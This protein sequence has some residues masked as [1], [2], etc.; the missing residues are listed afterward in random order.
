M[1]W[2]SSSASGGTL[3]SHVFVWVQSLTQ[4]ALQLEADNQ[5]SYPMK[6]A[7]LINIDGMSA[8]HGITSAYRVL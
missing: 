5:W 7:G 4:C 6:P 8:S 1:G 3:L 2:H